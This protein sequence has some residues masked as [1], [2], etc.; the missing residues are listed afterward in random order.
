MNNPNN[1]LAYKQFVLDEIAKLEGAIPAPSTQADWNQN[2]S[3][4]P[5][6]VKNRTH[7]MQ[8]VET[9]VW[10]L[11]TNYLFDTEIDGVYGG[12]SS[13]NFYQIQ[14]NQKYRFSWLEKSS[15]NRYNFCDISKTITLE[16]G[17]Y[18]WIGNGTLLE[19]PITIEPN[20]IGQITY[21][22]RM[23]YPTI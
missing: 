9:F 7:W 5:D 3:T 10:N 15:N 2:D 13:D 18:T 21:T 19:S 1:T 20:G 22:I 6:Y 14:P 12:S 4:Q 17:I 8:N 23:N 11:D 16:N